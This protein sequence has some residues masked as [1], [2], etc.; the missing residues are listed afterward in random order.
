M[1]KAILNRV[2]INKNA[3][4]KKKKIMRILPSINNNKLIAKVKTVCRHL[5]ISAQKLSRVSVNVVHISH[6]KETEPWPGR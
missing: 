6:D 3:R 2:V 5:S 1:P 4:S